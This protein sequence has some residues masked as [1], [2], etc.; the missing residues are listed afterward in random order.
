LKNKIVELEVDPVL[1]MSG[2]GQKL[3]ESLQGQFPDKDVKWVGFSFHYVI[4]DTMA[5]L[6]GYSEGFNP[7]NYE[8]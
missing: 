7:D 5:T 3:K 8:K 2:K 4:G 1:T 6:S